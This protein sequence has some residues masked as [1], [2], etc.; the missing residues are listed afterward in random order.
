MDK[1][2]TLTL[3][4]GN[5]I[6][7]IGL[8]TWELDD[9]VEAVANALDLGYRLIDTSDDYGTQMGIGEAIKSSN[10]DRKE[11]FITTKVSVTD[12]SYARTKSNLDE[13][14]LDYIDL[15]LIH[16]PPPTGSGKDLWDGLMKAKNDGLVK[17][18]GVSNYTTDLIDRLID[19]SGEVPMVNQVEWTPFGHNDDVLN[20]CKEKGIIIQAYSPLTRSIM[21][22]NETLS[23]LAAK[24][25]KSNAQI[26]LR[27]DLQHGVIP[28]PKAGYRV[29]QEENINVFDFELSGEDMRM[30]DDLNEDYSTLG[31]WSLM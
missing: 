1:T 29:H 27:W 19:E 17:D 7:V 23:L 26:M 12:D 9:A 21:L 8:G 31:G 4:S 10:L 14:G 2:S 16:H 6:P 13:L 20:Y 15:E 24:Y 22:N 5:K 25:G 30:I 18:I 28:L 3:K 11:I